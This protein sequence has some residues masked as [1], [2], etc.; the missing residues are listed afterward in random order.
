MT[1]KTIN[2]PLDATNNSKTIDLFYKRLLFQ[3]EAYG[4][5]LGSIGCL[6]DFS[7]YENN[8]YG[9]VD[10]AFSPRNPFSEM[11]VLVGD[12][13]MAFD[14]VAA[15]FDSFKLDIESKKQQGVFASDF[16]YIN[17]LEVAP[18]YL[19]A[20]VLFEINFREV[21]DI[22]VS[23]IKKN[24]KYHKYMPHYNSYLKYVF[25]P[26]LKQLIPAHVITFSSFM[27]GDYTSLLST[28]LTIDIAD[29]DAS[30]DKVK[31]DNFISKGGFNHYLLAAA[32]A[33]F[34]VDTNVPWRL[35]YNVG[36]SPFELQSYFASYTLPAQKDDIDILINLSLDVYNRF[37]NERKYIVINNHD[38]VKCHRKIR[39]SHAGD[40]TV[41]EYTNLSDWV[42]EYV[43]IKNLEANRLYTDSE[44]KVII[45]KFERTTTGVT[46]LTVLHTINE[47]FNYPEANINSFNAAVLR[48]K[49]VELGKS[50]DNFPDYVKLVV[51]QN[52]FGYY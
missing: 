9:R 26:L 51:K 41:A 27:L 6:R 19:D 42:S 40:D 44:I 20:N 1:T 7:L 36:G 17:N 31:I 45:N 12:R 33:N 4:D 37:V 52:T 22:I 38:G 50:L 28:G 18:S 32:K 23:S 43:Y 30:S 29:L 46:L 35:V 25:F 21:T 15:A 8:L 3:K 16:D 24:N 34:Y 14:F 13:H 48:K 5:A 11:M 2:I 47:Y 10:N 39:L 49:F